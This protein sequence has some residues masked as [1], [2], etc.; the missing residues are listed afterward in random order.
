M[1]Q[2]LKLTFDINNYDELKLWQIV[3]CV[4]SQLLLTLSQ[5]HILIIV[6]VILSFI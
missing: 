6:K 3:A 1:Q 4:Q 2:F 5:N